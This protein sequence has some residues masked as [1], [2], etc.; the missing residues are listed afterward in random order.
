MAKLTIE[1]LENKFKEV[2]L[3]A[4]DGVVRITLAAVIANRLFQND[5]PVWLL[6]LAGSSAGKTAI[7]QTLDTVGDWIVPIDTLTTNTFASGLARSEET[8]LLH[9]ANRGVMIFKDFTTLTSMNEE[10]LRDIMGQLRAIYDGSFDKKTG[11]NQDIHWVGK[12]GIIGGGTIAVQRKMRQFSEQGERFI[13]Y[14][15]KQ[16]NAIEMTTRAVKNQENLK[17]KEDSLK[18]VVKFF[19]EQSLDKGIEAKLTI[20]DELEKEIIVVADFSTLARSPVILD[21]KTNRVAW[22]PEREMPARMAIQLINIGKS[23]MIMSAEEELSRKNA[24]IL[25]QCAMDS[26]PTERRLVMKVLTQYK[27]ASTKNLAIHLNYPTDPVLSWC[28]QL[29]ARKMI[30][31]VARGDGSSDT[32]VLKPEYRAVMAKYEN[33]TVLEEHLQVSAEDEQNY[34]AD[35]E[36]KAAG[37]DSLLDELYPADPE[38]DEFGKE[39]A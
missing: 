25:Y 19:I 5:K 4:D 7:L 15:I 12:L 16:P 14:C 30:D 26:I 1:Q 32:W 37:E 27:S 11:N 3:L 22:V 18:E 9:K 36:A 10:A 31:R 24:K 35:A 28:S 39:K 20:P 38:F 29:N 23:L 34:S 13:N 6:L 17:D 33:I 21:K 8:S 2:Y